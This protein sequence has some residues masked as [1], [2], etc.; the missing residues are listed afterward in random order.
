MC[1][2][3]NYEDMVRDYDPDNKWVREAESKAINEELPDY[4]E[5]SLWEQEKIK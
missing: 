2:Y 5:R 4:Q 3:T 1:E